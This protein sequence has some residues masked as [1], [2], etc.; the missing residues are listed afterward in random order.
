VD[1]SLLKHEKNEYSDVYFG[2]LT[3]KQYEELKKYL[4]GL[5]L[6]YTAQRLEKNKFV[7][8]IANRQLIKGGIILGTGE[9]RE[10]I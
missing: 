5:S 1:L 9:E 3:E 6:G 2:P 7:L 8:I 4:T 10:S